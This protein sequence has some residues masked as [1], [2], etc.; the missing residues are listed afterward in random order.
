MRRLSHTF[1][2]R[3]ESSS[4]DCPIRRHLCW[5]GAVWEYVGH[6]VWLFWSWRRAL[7][8]GW[9]PAEAKGSQMVRSGFIFAI[10]SQFISRGGELATECW[11]KVACLS[12]VGPWLLE[13][14]LL[15][16]DGRL[17]Q[18]ASLWSAPEGF[19]CL[20]L[21]DVVEPC[22]RVLV[23]LQ[24]L[25]SVRLVGLY[26]GHCWALWA[27]LLTEHNLACWKEHVQRRCGFHA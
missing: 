14:R 1:F 19:I 12:L 24:Q 13:G 17:A 16:R 20:G 25:L 4:Q 8:I 6:V 23:E 11:V 7:T 2:S 3:Q 26:R 15:N 18:N 10:L 27:S 9:G 21:G 5:F 22:C